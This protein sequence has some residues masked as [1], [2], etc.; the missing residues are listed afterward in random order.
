M[1]HRYGSRSKSPARLPSSEEQRCVPEIARRYWIEIGAAIAIPDVGCHDNP[2]ALRQH[3]E[4][5]A[6]RSCSCDKSSARLDLNFH[7]ALLKSQNRECPRD[8]R[9]TNPELPVPVPRSRLCRVDPTSFPS[10]ASRLPRSS[11]LGGKARPGIVARFV[12]ARLVTPCFPATADASL[13][14]RSGFA[15]H[16]PLHLYDSKPACSMV[17]TYDQISRSSKRE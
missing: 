8:A 16:S 12:Q 3:Y 1:A 6:V 15:R 4:P 11:I 13:W 2:R 14:W 10:I 9:I 17:P 7:V 5:M